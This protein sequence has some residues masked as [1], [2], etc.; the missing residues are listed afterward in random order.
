MWA[1]TL[2]NGRQGQAVLPLGAGLQFGRA[3]VTG[4]VVA[5]L[6]QVDG[7]IG[8][9]GLHLPGEVAQH[10]VGAVAHGDGQR[11]IGGALRVEAELDFHAGE[12]A[13]FH[14]FL[15]ED[16]EG[17]QAQ[18]GDGGHGQ[19]QCLGRIA[20]QQDEP[21]EDEYDADQH[22][23]LLVEGPMLAE[24]RSELAREGAFASKLA[25]TGADQ[26]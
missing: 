20:Q 10:G 9:E 25:P 22:G 18:P 19:G 17:H 7:V 16:P 12:A 13:F 3:E 2:A 24:R 1:I 15:P 21:G 14:L 11:P 23:N 8:T 26:L 4:T 5:G 6:G